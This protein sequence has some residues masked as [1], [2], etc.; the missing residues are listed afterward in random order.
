[1]FHEFENVKIKTTGMTGVIVDKY[2]RDDKPF[3]VIEGDIYNA[4]APGG[5]EWP[6]YDCAEE[7][8]VAFS[9]AAEKSS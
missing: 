6:I 3:Y 4:S 8:I 2:F 1:M 5:G 7:D 9:P